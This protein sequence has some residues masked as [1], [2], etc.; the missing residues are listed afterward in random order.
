MEACIPVDDWPAGFPRPDA[1]VHQART[2]LAGIVEIDRLGVE[3]ESGVR[4]AC[5]FALNVSIEDDAGIAEI[6]RE[7]R[8]KDRATDVLSF[9]AFDF[10]PGPGTA[11]IPSEELWALLSEWPTPGQAPV[12]EVGDIVIS[13]ESCVRQ[14]GEIGHSVLD[15]FQRLLVHGILHLFG[16][17]HE[18]GAA[19][20]ERMRARED[21]LLSLFD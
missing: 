5:A 14:A 1:I 4:E 10:P 13:Y 3:T 21:R 19:D 11:E 2:A 17:D 7:Q 9:P 12:Y 20:E 8:Q 18:T 6:N 15:E 16:Y